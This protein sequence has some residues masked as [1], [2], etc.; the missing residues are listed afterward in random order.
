M[1]KLKPICMS[2][3]MIPALMRDEFPKTQT[4]RII[5]PR[6]QNTTLVLTPTGSVMEMLDYEHRHSR[7][8]PTGHGDKMI[9]MP[10]SGI[11]IYPQYEPGDALWVRERHTV[12]PWTYN[13]G[14]NG[15]KVLYAAYDDFA[16]FFDRALDKWKP[17]IYMPYQYARTFL[18][19]MD[20]RAERLQ[21]IT[22]EDA[23]AEGIIF[24][25]WQDTDIRSSFS[26]TWNFINGKRLK[27][28]YAWEKNPIVW[29]YT[30]RRI[31][32]DEAEGMDMDKSGYI[33]GE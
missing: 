27:G 23:V 7:R 17:S 22:T 33:R 16:R 4:R 24:A 20:V 18:R 21:S 28:E 10:S 13:S 15:Q 3:E 11:E 6:Y 31:S 26:E 14:E 25:T 29:V 5:R 2:V 9:D 8:V 1:S 32:K 19:V 12:I 30:I